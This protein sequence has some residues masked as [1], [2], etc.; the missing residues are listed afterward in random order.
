V[1]VVSAEAFTSL[2]APPRRLTTPDCPTPY[3]ASLMAEVLPNAESI[4]TAIGE[5]L[6]F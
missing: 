4:D 2:D 5:L 6:D 3:A 1:A